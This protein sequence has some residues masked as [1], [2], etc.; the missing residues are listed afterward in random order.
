MLDKFFRDYWVLLLL[1]VVLIIFLLWFSNC[2]N[3]W[4][5]DS[6]S[7]CDDSDDDCED[8]CAPPKREIKRCPPKKYNKCP[9]KKK[10]CGRGNRSG[11]CFTPFSSCLPTVR[12]ERGRSCGGSKKKR[13]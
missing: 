6:D 2:R 11:N 8:E 4:D 3:D 12:I 7:D 13:C 5:W 9:P 1:I 10:K